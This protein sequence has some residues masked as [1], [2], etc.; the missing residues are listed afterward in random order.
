M[1]AHQRHRRA[2][3]RLGQS[4]T[5]R[6]V[7]YQHVGGWP[8][9]VSDLEYRHPDAEKSAKMEYRPQGHPDDAKWDHCRRVAVHDRLHFGLGFVD[10]AMDEALEISGASARIDGVAVEIEFHDIDRSDQRRRHASRQ[11]V[12][13]RVLVVPG[14]DMT[15]AVE[16]TL[17]GENAIGS[18]EIIDQ[19]GIRRTC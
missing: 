5:E 15:K 17:A 13:S 10:L 1:A 4:R 18:D 6:R 16:H 19:F 2:P 8:A 3:D 7:A 14:T 9:G 12:A 11:Q